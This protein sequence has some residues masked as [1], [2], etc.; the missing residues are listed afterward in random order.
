MFG[1]GGNDPG[2]GG[3]MMQERG[4]VIAASNPVQTREQVTADVL[5]QLVPGRDQC[6]PFAS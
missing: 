2:E 4:G 1:A 5:L 3:T 6:F